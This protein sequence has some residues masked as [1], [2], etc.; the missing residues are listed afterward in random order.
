MSLRCEY[1]EKT[2]STKSSLKKHQTT[3]KKC[4]EIQIKINKKINFINFKC[5]YCNKNFTSKQTKDKHYSI[6][7]KKNK[8]N[9]DY[10]STILNLKKELEEKNIIISK[11]ET[12]L[13]DQS[14]FYKKE[15]EKREEQIKDLQAIIERMGT[16]AIEK[17]TKT[18]TNNT[19]NNKIQLNTFPSQEEIDNKIGSKFND[20]YILDGWKGIAQFV[21]DHVIT[22]EDGTIAYGCY[23]ISRQIFKYKDKDGN[24]IKDPKAYK[25]KKMIK[26]GL[27]SQT[28]TMYDFFN[29]EL[30]F[31]DNKEKKG[32]DIDKNEYTKIKLL[33]EKS[34]KVGLDI[35]EIEESNKFNNELVNLTC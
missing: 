18:I 13:E 3:T 25:L 31:L 30:D 11:I 8:N 14:F 5:E 16:K 2:F 26:P 34:L 23:D 1:C 22:L 33:K 15:L 19:I 9:I 12:R 28:K 4:L 20:K 6:C 29:E 10:E 21:Y 32:L 27:L 35:N 24:E 7:I 17:T